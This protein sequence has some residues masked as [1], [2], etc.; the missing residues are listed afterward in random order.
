MI[1]T[2]G[3]I[4]VAL[5]W[6]LVAGTSASGQEPP[7]PSGVDPGGTAV[8]LLGSGVDYTRPEVAR[9]LARDGEGELI[10][11]D[12]TDNDNRPHATS[13]GA[14]GSGAAD[15][16]IVSA[17]AAL[18]F[19]VVKEAADD[20]VAL[21]RMIAFAVQT[22]ARIIVWPG[23]DPKRAD[24]PILAEAVQRFPK[25]LFVI[26][27]VQGAKGEKNL[28][29]APD[30]TPP[31]VAAITLAGQLAGLMASAPELGA[32]EIRAKLTRK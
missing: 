18:R 7:V 17:P 4:V 27:A 25:H 6:L 23:A 15:D 1:E 3:R 24:W 29:V 28:F 32:D 9:R 11:W 16:L 19:V 30:G 5:V 2:I 20:K 22:P 10:G 13:G 21:G 14:T 8:A 26:P 31:G 12:F